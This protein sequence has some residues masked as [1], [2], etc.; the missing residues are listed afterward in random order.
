MSYSDQDDA[1]VDG[2]ACFLLGLA[3][4]LAVTLGTALVLL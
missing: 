1:V 2:V 4:C 3:L